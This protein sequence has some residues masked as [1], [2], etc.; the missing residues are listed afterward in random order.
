MTERR[1]SE[2]EAIAADLIPR[3]WDVDEGAIRIGGIDVRDTRSNDLMEQ[4]ALVFQDTFLFS[5]SVLEN[6]RVGRPYCLSG[7]C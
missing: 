1:A 5:D 7:V 4:V 2:K 6:I 3:F